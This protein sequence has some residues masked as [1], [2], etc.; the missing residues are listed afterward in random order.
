MQFEWNRSKAKHNL[1]KHGVSFEEASSVFD[2]VLANIYEDPDHSFHEKRFI[3]IGNSVRGRL[4]F[5]AFADRDRRIR[6]ISARV[7]TKREK[8]LYEEE[9]R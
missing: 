5:I 9:S 7:L 4:L 3:M 2:D 6:I 8:K 1:R